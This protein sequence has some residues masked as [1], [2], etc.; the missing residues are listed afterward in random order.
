MKQAY[1]GTGVIFYG[2]LLLSG[3]SFRYVLSTF[4]VFTPQ[5]SCLLFIVKYGRHKCGL[6]S[7]LFCWINQVFDRSCRGLIC[8]L[9]PSMRP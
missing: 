6:A 5:T 1:L 2:R 4:K 9:L 8:S 3:F 7:S